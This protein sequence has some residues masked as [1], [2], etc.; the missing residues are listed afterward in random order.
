M[1]RSWRLNKAKT[2]VKLL[3]LAPD[4]R[5]HRDRVGDILWPGAGARAAANNLH[6]VVHAVRN[7]VGPTSIELRDDMVRL[8][9]RV[10]VDVD[11]FERAA[12]QARAT[13]E[14]DALQAA[15]RLWTG[16][17][18]PEDLYAEWST[19]A[20][21]RLSESHAA[22]VATLGAALFEAGQPEAA[23]AQV[24]SLA[25]SRPLD[26]RLHRLFIELLV[27]GGRR[28]E[29]IEAYER[30]RLALDDAYAAEPERRTRALYRRLLTGGNPAPAVGPHNLPASSTSFVGRR[31]LLAELAH[32]LG[33]TRLLSLTGVGGVGKSRLAIELARLVCGRQEF[34]DGVWLVELA[35]IQ[36]SEVVPSTVAAALRI[37]L[38]GG[39]SAVTGLA[40]QL[41]GRSLLLVVDNCEHLLDAV[42][43][44]VSR[45]LARCPDVVV[46]ATSREPL[47]LPAE[48]V[49]RVPSLELPTEQ[50][51]GDIRELFG[52]EAVQLF[53]E[54]ACLAVPSFRLNTETA[55]PV[56]MICRQLDGIPLALELAA[57]RLAHLTVDEVAEGLGDALTLLGQ[58]GRGRSDRQQTLA[59]TLDW[60]HGLLVAGER[61]VFRRLAVFAGGFDIAGAAAVCDMP[62]RTV[63]AAISRLVDKSLVQA[64]ITGPKTR[65][66][67]LEV[68]RQ[69]AGPGSASHAELAACQRRHLHWFADAAAT[70]DPDRGDAVV[71]EPSG[72]FDVEQDNLR[73][74][75]SAAL[76]TDPAVALRL[77]TATWRFWVSRGLIAEGAWW[78]DRALGA[79]PHRSAQR[80]AALSARVVLLVRQGRPEELAV[81]GEEI[82]D[83]LDE[84]GGPDERA[85]ARHHRALLTFM[86]GDW[87]LAQTQNRETLRHSA[88]FPAACASAHH[89][90]G[91]LALGRGE[92]AAAH[93]EFDTALRLLDR[94]PEDAAPFF[95]TM[96][97]GWVV[98]ER[99]HPPLP[100]GEE[101]I[102]F[103]RRVGTRQ[104][105][106]HL[107]IALALTERLAGS[108]DVALSIIDEA[109]FCSIRR[110]I[111][112]GWPVPWHSGATRCD[113]SG[114]TP[115]PTGS[116]NG[117][118]RCDGNCVID[119]LW[120]CPCPGG[121]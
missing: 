65:Y 19:E 101:T 109:A 55:G 62:S 80:A 116:W 84:F 119:E 91:V 49:H 7:A 75:L 63:T 77:A 121:R 68:V 90:A 59:A 58:P 33:R 103:G 45:L 111:A 110:V 21:E 78:L 35:G 20:R 100:F 13:A 42:C 18:L 2:L 31:R 46:V 112:T 23:L 4:H 37:T 36:D 12:G 60:S 54:R 89:F 53:V 3:A 27:V 79:C 40:E 70:Q 115:R 92:P 51:H 17:L 38:P 25:P 64:D 67:L 48:L 6:Q 108:A 50:A 93:A 8:G 98:D 96:S 81:L 30:L 97:I 39:T 120:R 66:R 10:T 61:T 72:W 74:A 34:R 73:A 82:V 83:L 105:I 47:A 28:W 1:T 5:L 107:Q 104:A 117:R 14:I 44:L 106:G 26:E 99:Y 102:L 32:G 41:A 87:G 43:A 22:L 113:G 11:T 71:G 85:H 9:G 86:A 16:P 118:N 57:A 76:A 69:Y 88:G 52:P 24:E 56:A 29:A 94:V 95:V 114:D 15:L